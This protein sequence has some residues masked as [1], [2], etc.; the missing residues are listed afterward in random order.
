MSDYPGHLVRHGPAISSLELVGTLVIN[1]Q[2]VSINGE[3]GMSLSYEKKFSFHSSNCETT[4]FDD[5]VSFEGSFLWN[6]KKVMEGVDLS[7]AL[8]NRIPVTS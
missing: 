2:G 4:L 6:K 7:F 8:L 3:W 5:T 1:E